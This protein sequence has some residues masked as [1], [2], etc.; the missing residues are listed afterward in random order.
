MFSL[1]PS[2][3]CFAELLVSQVLLG[4]ESLQA[5]AP[6]R[7]QW[8]RF[9][10]WAKVS[11][12]ALAWLQMGLSGVF[13]CRLLKKQTNIH[14][15]AFVSPSCEAVKWCCWCSVWGPVDSPP[16]LCP[17]MWVS[18]AQAPRTRKLTS[19]DRRFLPAARPLQWQQDGDECQHRRRR[20]TLHW[21]LERQGQD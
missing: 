2:S 15:E 18:F 8:T 17:N 11:L 16:L 10:P 4:C 20:Q 1:S 19:S 12:K 14:A 5:T 9:T 7:P 21:P 6:L 3:F 13:Q